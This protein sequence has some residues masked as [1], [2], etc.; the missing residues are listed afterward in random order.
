MIMQDNIWRPVKTS[1]KRSAPNKIVPIGSNTL[2]TE[3]S[4]APICRMLYCSKM[5][6][7]N[8]PTTVAR[9]TIQYA[10]GRA[11]HSNSRF[12]KSII[13]MPTNTERKL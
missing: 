1:P 12:S 4:P 9:I 11:G 5:E 13:A 8:R 7:R 6:P 3:F 2:K 10:F